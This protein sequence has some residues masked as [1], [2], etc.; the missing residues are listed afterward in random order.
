MIWSSNYHRAFGQ[1][2]WTLFFAGK[3][4]AP[5]CTINGQNIQDFLQDHFINAVGE[6]AKVVAAAGDGELLDSCVLGW[7]SIN[8]PAEGHIGMDDL[9]VVP[10]EQSVRLGPVPTPFENMQLSMGQAV[11]VDHY[12]F[13]AMG[14]SKTGRV[15]LDPRGTRLWITPE[16]DKKRGAGRYGWRRGDEW[17]VGT[18]SEFKSRLNLGRC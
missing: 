18:C 5:K 16:D 15:T 10:K 9:S 2:V 13:T 6:L 1:T 7:D 11:T 3:E 4:F 8:E 17:E 12:K 14:P